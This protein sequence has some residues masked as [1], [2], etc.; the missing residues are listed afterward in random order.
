V[1]NSFNVLS[2]SGGKG[3]FISAAQVQSIGP[4]EDS[5][6][7]AIVPEPVT[8]SALAAVLLLHRRR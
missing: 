8:L 3:P 7:I 6:W 4:S 1:A 5:G 2:V